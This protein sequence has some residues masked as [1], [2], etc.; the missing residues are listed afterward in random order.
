MSLGLRWGNPNNTEESSGFIYLDAPLKSDDNSGRSFGLHGQIT[1]VGWLG[2]D[3][4]G[5]KVYIVECSIVT[6]K[7]I[8]RAHV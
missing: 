6:G 4:S 2:K 5:K 8:G 7:Q 3:K 1:I